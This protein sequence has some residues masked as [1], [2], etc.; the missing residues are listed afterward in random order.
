MLDPKYRDGW[1]LGRRTPVQVQARG[2][3]SHRRVLLPDDL[4]PLH[5]AGGGLPPG[6]P[7]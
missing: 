5:G 4:A 3:H 6:S 1:S 2:A 7:A